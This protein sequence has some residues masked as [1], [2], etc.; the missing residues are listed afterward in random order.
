LKEE[1]EKEK[2]ATS[3]YEDDVTKTLLSQF[4]TFLKQA[5]AKVSAQKSTRRRTT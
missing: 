3:F 1:L 5:K 4:P 2:E